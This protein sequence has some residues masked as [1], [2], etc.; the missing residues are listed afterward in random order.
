MK[1]FASE[2][3]FK[4]LSYYENSFASK[5][6]EIRKEL[7]N[8]SLDK[9]K[10][11]EK[12]TLKELLEKQELR[13]ESLKKII[14]FVSSGIYL[15]SDIEKFISQNYKLKDKQLTEKWNE[16][17]ERGIREGRQKSANTFRG[18]RSITSQKAF[19][20]LNETAESL[21]QKISSDDEE[22]YKLANRCEKAF[23]DDIDFNTAFKFS[24][25]KFIGDYDT[26]K[27]YSVEE[28]QEAIQFLKL[29]SNSNLQRLASQIDKDKL[30]CAYMRCRAP[31]FLSGEVISTSTYTLNSKDNNGVSEK[32]VKTLYGKKL[33]DA[34]IEI[35]SYF[36]DVPAL[37]LQLSD[38]ENMVVV[39]N[40]NSDIMDEEVAFTI[41]DLEQKVIKSKWGIDLNQKLID[42]LDSFLSSYNALSSEEKY[43]Y[44]KNFQDKNVDEDICVK[45]CI[46]ELKQFNENSSYTDFRIWVIK[47]DNYIL[48]LVLDKLEREN[49]SVRYSSVSS[50]YKIDLNDD[51]SIEVEDYRSVIDIPDELFTSLVEYSMEAPVSGTSEKRETLKKMLA[52]FTKGGFIDWLKK[53]QYSVE[54]IKVVLRDIV[55]EDN[56]SSLD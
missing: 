4:L 29:I 2:T 47:Q 13:Y 22:F 39:S 46:Y 5:V 36:H 30:A 31:L 18:Q 41:E 43:K 12:K 52:C 11:Q 1:N 35:N 56:N 15:D 7:D 20:V 42:V 6:T 17:I 51:D 27:D 54:D 38:V 23:I 44:L 14:N 25:S 32:K 49:S 3:I 50:E 40:D 16:E 34:K 8:I 45:K 53:K 33:N 19:F 26:E 48:S 9:Q 28:L 37:D 24:L 55:N 21:N 10:E